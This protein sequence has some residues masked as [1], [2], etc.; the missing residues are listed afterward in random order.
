MCHLFFN[1]CTCNYIL[2][3][4]CILQ[5]PKGPKA[6][7]K[8]LDRQQSK[9]GQAGTNTVIEKLKKRET[10]KLKMLLESR[11]KDLQKIKDLS[12][13]KDYA[14]TNAGMKVNDLIGKAEDIYSGI[15]KI[16]RQ[17]VH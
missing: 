2:I 6:E 1:C 3:Y 8:T 13:R 16:I 15:K 5:E 10:D 14:D 4:T 17:E 11:E 12:S 7:K 9:Q